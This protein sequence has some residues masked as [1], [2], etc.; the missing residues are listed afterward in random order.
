MVFAIELETLLVIE[1]PTLS[2][3]DWFTE[4]LRDSPYVYVLP[5]NGESFVRIFSK[6]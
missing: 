4:S 1:I 6:S 5:T 2:E 3:K